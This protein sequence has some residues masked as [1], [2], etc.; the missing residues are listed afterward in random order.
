MKN[1]KM[2]L[3]LLAVLSLLVACN[4][5]QRADPACRWGDCQN[6]WGFYLWQSGNFYMGEWQQQQPHGFGTM[7]WADGRTYTGAWQAGKMQGQGTHHQANAQQRIGTWQM[8]EYTEQ[9]STQMPDYQYETYLAHAQEQLSEMLLDR[10][11]LLPLW[12]KIEGTPLRTWLLAQLAGEALRAPVFWQ[13]AADAHFQIPP[14][15]HALHRSPSPTHTAAIW[16]KDSLS[17]EESWACVVF[18]L[19]NLQNAPA[20]AD[21]NRDVKLLK[22][23]E[24]E[25]IE[26]YAQLEYKAL[27]HLRDFYQTQWLPQLPNHK[28]SPEEAQYWAA[29]LP[30]TYEA[31]RA[32]FTDPDGY[33][34]HPYR[35][36]YRQQVQNSTKKY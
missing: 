12:E 21:I 25:F 26:R 19:F 8:G 1:L 11:A 33:P 3:H 2:R 14:N 20:F 9:Q 13:N 28:N 7:A 24:N 5:S 18:E 36:Y 10:P 16:I 30:D 4:S 17:T 32:Q 34:Y 22:C 35:L 15:I 6:G 29:Y 23:T 31:W 27:Q